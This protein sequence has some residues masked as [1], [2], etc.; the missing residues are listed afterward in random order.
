MVGF[1]EIRT[2]IEALSTVLNG[3]RHLLPSTTALFLA[4]R[5]AGLCARIRPFVEIALVRLAHQQFM[6]GDYTDYVHTMNDG[7]RIVG[8]PN[9]Y[10]TALAAVCLLRLARQQWQR[11]CGTNAVKWLVRQQ[12][13]EGYWVA[14]Q[15]GQER[16][17]DLLTTILA[18]EAIKLSGNKGLSYSL[19]LGERWLAS[20]Q[21]PTGEWGGDKRW[22]PFPFE[23]VLVLEYL[24]RNA[25]L[26]DALTNYLKLARGFLYRASEMALEDDP[27]AW[28][29]ALVTG[30]QALEAFL[31]GLLT[32]PSINADVF[33][34]R[35]ETIGVRKALDT[36]E[37]YLKV[38]GILSDQE[39]FPYRSDLNRLAYLRDE[40]VH[41]AVGVPAEECREL[42]VALR[43]F[44]RQMSLLV[45]G[46]TLV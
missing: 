41:K 9:A 42:I 12:R 20:A 28:R 21:R 24:S 13:A 8:A 6:N 4:S 15:D 2:G 45:L 33:R 34:T 10:L 44:V 19:T 46:D 32:Q 16:P 7:G 37:A 23:T 25:V 35:N 1:A 38:N 17:P 11:E 40:V 39:Q 18:L 30:Y 3:D 43:T 14:I 36:L 22:P 26:P 27:N 29:L 5:S 31:Y